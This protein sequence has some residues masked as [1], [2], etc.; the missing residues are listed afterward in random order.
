MYFDNFLGNTDLIRQLEL[1]AAEKRIPHAIILEGPKGSG[2]HTIAKY[3]A[4]LL[5]CEGGDGVCLECPSCKRIMTNNSPDVVSVG[6]LEGKTQLVIESIRFVR[7]DVY[8]KPN[9]GKFKVYI[10]EDADKMTTDAQNAFL[11]VLE[12]PPSYAVF[13]MLCE[14][15]DSLLITVKSRSRVY[16]TEIFDSSVLYDYFIRTNPDAK[17]L[18]EESDDALKLALITSNGSVGQA[19]EAIDSEKARLNLDLYNH[20]LKLL[21]LLRQRA[22]S[23]DISNHLSSVEFTRDSLSEYLKLCQSGLFDALS[24]KLSDK[25]KLSYFLDEEKFEHI[26]SGLTNKFILEAIELIEEARQAL[27]YVVNIPITTASLASKLTK[28]RSKY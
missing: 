17:K 6:L 12:E 16:K 3:I 8:I 23:F 7:S 5:S 1:D 10:I 25:S 26:S 22:S 11:K 21:M 28:L 4:L 13:I 9:D 14:S 18:A 2:R 24:N 27:H 15:A 20:S 19:A